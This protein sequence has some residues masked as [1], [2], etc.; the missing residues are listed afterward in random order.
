VL[1]LNH[2][3]NGGVEQLL[4]LTRLFDVI[5]L[6]QAD[7]QIADG[8]ARSIEAIVFNSGRP[9]LIVPYVQ[10]DAASLKNVLVAWDAG[11]PAA[12]ALGDALPL[13]AHASRVE[14]IR[15]M[16]TGRHDEDAG[17]AAITRHLAPHEIKA[18]FRLDTSPV[19]VGNTLLS[20]AADTSADI[21]VMGAYGH[22]RLREALFGGTTRTMLQS[23][24]IPVLMS[25]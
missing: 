23:M 3:E 12:R 6:E 4:A 9:A 13:L 22:S 18:A 2:F 19:D 25:R 17:G 21:L 20:Y 10:K 16:E 1:S 14:L 5:V 7:A 15:I 24:T 8:R 11:A